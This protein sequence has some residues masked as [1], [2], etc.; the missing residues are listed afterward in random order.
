MKLLFK[1]SAVLL[2]IGCMLVSLFACTLPLSLGQQLAGQW[3]AR[4]VDA[5][6]SALTFTPSEDNIN[7]GEV[8]L[9]FLSLSA[10]ISGTYEVIPA[11][12]EGEKD[13]LN[14]TYTLAFVS[15]TSEYDFEIDG[16]TM[17]IYADG[18]LSAAVTFERVIEETATATDN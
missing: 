4:S 7:K 11:D 6:F 17:T 9:S 10:V 3:T 1:K 8:G 13:Q 14:I 12:E 5:D 15:H 2:A 16:D 18:L